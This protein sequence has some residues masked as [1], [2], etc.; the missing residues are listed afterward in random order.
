MAVKRAHYSC[1]IASLPLFDAQEII[2]K[3]MRMVCFV[4]KEVFESCFSPVNAT[5]GGWC[6][7]ALSR[8]YKKTAIDS[9]ADMDCITSMADDDIAIYDEM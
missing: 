1:S 5:Y 8:Y 6:C 7:S 4:C 2:L 3:L 9:V